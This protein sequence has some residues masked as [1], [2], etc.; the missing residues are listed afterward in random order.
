MKKLMA[1]LLILAAAMNV[2]AITIDA[3]AK[4]T[5]KAIASN[6][7]EAVYLIQSAD[8]QDGLNTGYCSLV[9]NLDNKPVAIYAYYNNAEYATFGTKDLGAL[10]F[11]L[12]T[13]A[14]TEYQLIVSDVEGATLVM[15]DD[16]E[17]ATFNLTEGA[18]YDFTAAANSTINNR[19]HLYIAPAAPGICHYGDVLQVTGSNGMTVQIN[20]M[21]DTQAIAPV[22]ITSDSQDIDISGLTAGN[23]YKVVWNSQTLII[24]K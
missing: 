2:M 16:A 13:N 20:N 8:L 15:K 3:K 1:S 9:P 4:I 19:F 14:D 11:G 12:K 22:A 5:L 21:D 24:R 7:T 10:A 18:T 17:N 6:K 23:Q